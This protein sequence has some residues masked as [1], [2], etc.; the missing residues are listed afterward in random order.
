MVPADKHDAD[1]QSR[2]FSLA[3]KLRHAGYGALF[4]STD[5]LMLDAV[6]N[7]PLYRE[8][9][10][11]LVVDREQEPLVRFLAAEIMFSRDDSY[12]PEE[13]RT[14]LPGIY[15]QALADNFAGTANAWGIPG[16][17]DGV[18]GEHVMALGESAVPVFSPL[19]QDERR[20]YYAG[21]KEATYADA[22]S[23]RVKDLAAYYI[24]QIRNFPFPV[25]QSSAE[26]DRTIR[27]LQTVVH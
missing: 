26:R 16:L 12:P 17:L 24:S 7:D 6:W 27:H 9:L 22:W 10:P 2:K 14:A 19:L 13:H 4:Q 8:V 11:L 25:E 23:F 15:A 5:E 21:S 1:R 18:L 20:V 3:A